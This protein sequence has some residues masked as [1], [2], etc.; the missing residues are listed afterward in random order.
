M[1][2]PI[3]RTLTSGYIRL[4]GRDLTVLRNHHSQPG[5][6][7]ATRVL[8]HHMS[9]HGQWGSKK[10]N[11]WPKTPKRD[12]KQ[13]KRKEGEGKG[14]F[15]SY[16]TV[17]LSSASSSTPSSST[18]EGALKSAMK[19]LIEANQMVVPAELKELLAEDEMDNVKSQQQTLNRKKKMLAKLER[20]RRAKQT[21]QAQWV[22]CRDNMA[23]RLREEQE[24][25]ERD[26]TEI[27]K[28]IQDV[29]LA[30]NDSQRRRS[31]RTGRTRSRSSAQGP[32]EDGD[33]QT[34]GTSPSRAERNPET[35]GTPSTT[36]TGLCIDDLDNDTSRS[37][38]AYELGS[39]CRSQRR[40]K[41]AKTHQDQEGRRSEGEGPSQPRQR[42]GPKERR[43]SGYEWNDVRREGL[44]KRT[45]GTDQLRDLVR[46]ACRT[47]L[48][49]KNYSGIL[50]QCHSLGVNAWTTMHGILYGNLGFM[51]DENAYLPQMHNVSPGESTNGPTSDGTDLQ[52]LSLHI[53]EE[54][55]ND[56]SLSFNEQGIDIDQPNRYDWQ[57]LEGKQFCPKGDGQTLPTYDTWDCEA[58]KANCSAAEV[59]G[60]YDEK[61]DRA[62]ERELLQGRMILN[63]L[64]IFHQ[65]SFMA[66]LWHSLFLF[67]SSFRELYSQRMSP[68]VGWL[69]QCLTFTSLDLLIDHIIAYKIG[70]EDDYREGIHIGSEM[71]SKGLH[72]PQELGLYGLMG[73]FLIDLKEQ[74]D[75]DTKTLE[76]IGMVLLS[77][78]IPV[79]L[80]LLVKTTFFLYKHFACWFWHRPSPCRF[81]GKRR[82]T[83]KN[84]VTAITTRHGTAIFFGWLVVSSNATDRFRMQ[85]D[86]TPGIENPIAEPP[87]GFRMVFDVG[88]NNHTC[89]NETQGITTTNNPLRAHVRRLAH[90]EETCRPV[91]AFDFCGDS[92]LDASRLTGSDSMDI[93]DPRTPAPFRTRHVSDTVEPTEA[94][95]THTIWRKTRNHLT[96]FS[97]CKG[98][99][100]VLRRHV[101]Y[102]LILWFTGTGSPS[103]HQLPAIVFMFG[104]RHPMWD[105]FS[106]ICILFLG[107]G[108]DVSDVLHLTSEE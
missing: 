77:W 53:S 21:K 32:R 27:Q 15:P 22:T 106:M 88:K 47:D 56:S 97:S 4:L 74:N 48:C 10:W 76:W 62:A 39:T 102:I 57:C 9:W 65:F 107:M 37:F 80:F 28:A 55:T 43:L 78:T 31:R 49:P 3:S 105:T 99:V 92:I 13:H 59:E 8:R 14:S 66:S 6:E 96:H 90:W 17:S 83:T 81:C 54:R 104:E 25:F 86:E 38:G 91:C 11:M 24:K 45:C 12:T 67:G 63:F 46:S 2:N 51:R 87:S 18:N 85:M 61:P 84:R 29:Q 73:E 89:Y 41:T 70:F 101:G 16:D 5:Y 100:L 58:G 33:V 52:H 7:G 69:G 26:Q 71:H 103:G 36:S 20:L 108:A 72:K 98:P 60:V 95:Y 79:I 50:A 40:G 23:Q 68:G 42:E 30:L 1:Q 19:H 64:N 82:I 75:V 34:V 35:A 94:Q 44:R 93:L